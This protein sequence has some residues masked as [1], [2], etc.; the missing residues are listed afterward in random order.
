[1]LV[2]RRTFLPRKRLF[3]GGY[4]WRA[5]GKETVLEADVLAGGAAVP[6]HEITARTTSNDRLSNVIECFSTTSS[7]PFHVQPFCVSRYVSC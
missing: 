5:I 1:M 7:T 3:A 4:A 2:W 6:R